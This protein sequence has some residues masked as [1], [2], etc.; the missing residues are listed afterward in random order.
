[1]P[2]EV[3]ALPQEHVFHC[4]MSGW[5]IVRKSDSSQEGI[6][7][8][9]VGHGHLDTHACLLNDAIYRQVVVTGKPSML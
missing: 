7:R 2:V 6:H 5:L 1:M 4:V 9:F 8:E 3:H